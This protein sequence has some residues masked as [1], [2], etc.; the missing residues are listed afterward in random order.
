M[1]SRSLAYYNPDNV[2]E[3]VLDLCLGD[4]KEAECNQHSHLPI[5]NLQD[6]TVS[7]ANVLEK[8]TSLCPLLITL[9]SL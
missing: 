2:A 6:E 8:L 4:I 7:F 9:C 3:V 1:A 5:I